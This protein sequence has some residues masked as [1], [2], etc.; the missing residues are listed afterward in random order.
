PT[1]SSGV[2]V[3]HPHPKAHA[4]TDTHGKTATHSHPGVH[5]KAA[6]HGLRRKSDA[7]EPQ[8]DTHGKVEHT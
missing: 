6:T 3:T 2:T 4:H 8:A 1:K 5:G 7:H